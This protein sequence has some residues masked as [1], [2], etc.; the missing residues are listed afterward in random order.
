VKSNQF[1][2]A[3]SMSLF[4]DLLCLQG[5][6]IK[7]LKLPSLGLSYKEINLIAGKAG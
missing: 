4:Q 5:F 2:I 1:S 7:D 6:N 3:E